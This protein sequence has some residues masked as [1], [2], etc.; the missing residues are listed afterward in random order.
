MLLIK[1]KFPKIV[2]VRESLESQL[3]LLEDGWKTH[4]PFWVFQPK[5][6]AKDG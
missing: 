6:A 5:M 1:K 2:T 4:P 3:R